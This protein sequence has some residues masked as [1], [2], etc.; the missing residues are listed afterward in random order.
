MLRQFERVSAGTP[1]PAEVPQ[2]VC[3]DLLA[4]VALRA[5]MARYVGIEGHNKVIAIGAAQFAL[6]KIKDFRAGTLN[7]IPHRCLHRPLP[8]RPYTRLLHCISPLQSSFQVQGIRQWCSFRSCSIP[9]ACYKRHCTMRRPHRPSSAT[10]VYPD[11]GVRCRHI[12]AGQG[13]SDISY[14][15]RIFDRDTLTVQIFLQIFNSCRMCFV[16]VRPQIIKHKYRPVSYSLHV[17]LTSPN[18]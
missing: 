8:V 13:K 15:T 6:C 14:G 11:C 10:A 2:V 4:V 18:I 1:H 9:S 3:C 16:S 7:L 5:Q 17:H 12:P